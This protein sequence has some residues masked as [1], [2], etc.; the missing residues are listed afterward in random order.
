MGPDGPK[1]AN[2]LVAVTGHGGTAHGEVRKHTREIV[3]VT[4]EYDHRRGHLPL[5]VGQGDAHKASQFPEGGV[6]V[7]K[8]T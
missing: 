6:C 5:V 7:A 2:E 3:E 4:E 8:E 1:E